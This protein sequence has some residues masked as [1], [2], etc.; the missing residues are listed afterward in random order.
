V[1]AATCKGK[2][3][4]ANGRAGGL[5]SHVDCEFK[6]RLRHDGYRDH[7]G[8]GQDPRLV[9]QS[10]PGIW[11]VRRTVSRHPLKVEI[12]RAALA[13][14]THGGATIGVG[15]RLENGCGIIAVGSSNLSTSA[16]APIAQ[17][18]EQAPLKRRVFGS[19]P[20]GGTKDVAP[21]ARLAGHWAFNPD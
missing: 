9:N 14:A 8:T 16:F 19:N 4:W 21:S 15:Y 18:L 7:P 1:T 5:S 12:A 17:R 10:H 11:R 20:N 3:Q 13:R 2:A 6:S